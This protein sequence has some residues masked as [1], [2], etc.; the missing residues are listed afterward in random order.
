MSIERLSG[1]DLSVLFEDALRRA[2]TRR[3]RTNDPV[4]VTIQDIG[5]FK[6]ISDVD[7]ESFDTFAKRLG[8]R[9]GNSVLEQKVKVSSSSK[10]L[11]F[12]HDILF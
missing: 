8:A 12:L 1:L 11:T 6:R 5:I 9:Q 4:L 2:E 10:F 7:L 3:K